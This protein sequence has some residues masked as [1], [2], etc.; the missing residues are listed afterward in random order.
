MDGWTDVDE[1][2][3]HAKTQRAQRFSPDKKFLFSAF[4]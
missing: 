3:F 4:S 2:I 1:E